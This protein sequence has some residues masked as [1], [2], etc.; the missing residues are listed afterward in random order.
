MKTKDSLSKQVNIAVNAQ[1]DS[2]TRFYQRFSNS[3]ES[4]DPC[5]SCITT[6]ASEDLFETRDD[7]LKVLMINTP[8]R[9]WS[10]PR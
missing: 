10:Y 9:E 5:L 6:G 3:G 7:G 4:L 8:I 2:T 1:N